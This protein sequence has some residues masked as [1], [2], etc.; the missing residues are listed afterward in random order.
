[1][2]PRQVFTA[3]DRAQNHP[4]I[5]YNFCPHC[6]TRIKIVQWNDRLREQCPACEWIHY[7]NALPGVVTVIP[8]GERVLLT[9]RAP[10]SFME[11]TW[12]LPGGFIEWDEDFLSAGIRET[13]EE[14]GLEIGIESILTV[15]SNFLVPTL[16][17]FVVTLL[18]YIVGGEM[19][20]GDDASALAWFRFDELPPMAFEADTHIIE[21]YFAQRFAGAPVD[22]S[23]ASPLTPPSPLS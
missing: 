14:T 22:P 2:R 1:M 6:G 19:K 4:G 20:P 5:R 13:R 10:G 21:R 9:K 15:D 16:H 3:Y 8:D 17:T 12:C 11:N 23:F 7:Q 18:G